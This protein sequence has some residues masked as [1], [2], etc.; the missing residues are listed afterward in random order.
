MAQAQTAGFE[1]ALVEADNKYA[2]REAAK[3]L[4]AERE[5]VARDEVIARELAHYTN[6]SDKLAAEN[7]ELREINRWL[8]YGV[9]TLAVLLVVSVFL[10]L[11]NANG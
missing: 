8:A 2:K 1:E 6:L 5:Q 11:A 9:R 10:G 4:I 7:Q 3:N